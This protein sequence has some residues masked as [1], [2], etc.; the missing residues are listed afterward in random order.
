MVSTGGTNL[1]DDIIR[2]D[3]RVHII[4]ATPGWI[5]DLA[6]KRIVWLNNC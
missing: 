2:L 5:L 6:N 4:V 1:R 3:K